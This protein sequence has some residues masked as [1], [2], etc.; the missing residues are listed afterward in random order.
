MLIPMLE[1]KNNFSIRCIFELTL[2]NVF[3][4]LHHV[5]DNVVIAILI[6]I[7]IWNYDDVNDEY[8]ICNVIK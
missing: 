5:F 4:V 8:N 1:I 6:I 2:D 7:I 3:N